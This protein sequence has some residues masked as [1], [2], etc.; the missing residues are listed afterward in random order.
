MGGGVSEPSL[1]DPLVPA[2]VDLRDFQYMELDVHLL[3][4]SKFAAEAEP[5]AFRAG[6]LLWC[7]AWHQ[8]PAGSLPNNDKELSGLAGFGRVVKEWKKVRDEALSLFV[9]CRDG[10]LYHPVIAEKALAAWQSRLRH[11][12]GKLLE[13]MRKDNKKREAEKMQPL[14]YPSF[15]EWNSARV[16]AET[17]PPSV[18]IPP[19]NGLKGNGEGTERRGNGEGDSSLSVP[20][21]TADADGAAEPAALPPPTP[22]ENARP[23]KV[24]NPD[25]IIFGYGVPLLTAAGIGEKQARSFLGGLRKAHGDTAVVD[26]LRSCVRENPLQPLE[27]LAKAMPPPATASKPEAE[28]ARRKKT[29]DEARVLLGLKSGDVIDA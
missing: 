2:D 16:P 15:D 22:V 1:P 18:G 20:I 14:P 5:E 4:D 11:S 21:G 28:A 25:E 19:E 23:P 8:V 17:K 27:W 10:R 6:V 12:H 9:L 29:D 26:K 24:T 7:A 3:R 13:R